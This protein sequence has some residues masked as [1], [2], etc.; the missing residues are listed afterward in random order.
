[1]IGIGEGEARWNI[2]RTWKLYL[3]S[4]ARIR[5]VIYHAVT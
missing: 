3:A 2:T 1:V 5:A 4:S